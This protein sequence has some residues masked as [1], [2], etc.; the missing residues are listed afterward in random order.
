[1]CVYVCACMHVYVGGGV[2]LRGG[3]DII[4]LIPQSLGH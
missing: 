2:C 4:V 1:M 3:K